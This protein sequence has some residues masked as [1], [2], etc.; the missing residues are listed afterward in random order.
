MRVDRHFSSLSHCYERHKSLPLKAFRRDGFRALD[1]LLVPALRI[2]GE[3]PVRLCRIFVCAKGLPVGQREA[4][5]PLDPIGQ[6]HDGFTFGVGYGRIS[7][8]FSLAGTLPDFGPRGSKKAIESNYAIQVSPCVL[9]QQVFQYYIDVE[10]STRI[11]KAAVFGL[12]TKVV[13]YKRGCI[14]PKTF[15]FPLSPEKPGCDSWCLL[16]TAQL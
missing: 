11:P 7:K 13:V 9:S 2:N 6:V 10:A 16:T 12:R 1:R 15:F 5:L 4:H 14:R 3:A 8:R